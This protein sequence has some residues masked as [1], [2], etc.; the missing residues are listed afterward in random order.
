MRTLRYLTMTHT[1]APPHRERPSF[2][3][4]WAQTLDGRLATRSGSSQWIS[5]SASLLMTHRLRANHDAIMVG[6]RTVLADDPRLTV[7]LP[8]DERA[9]DT[10]DP[11][12]II[13]DSRLSIPITARVLADGA[14][15]GT[16]I[17]TSVNAEPVRADALR[18]LGAT[19]LSV[20]AAS[21]SDVTGSH[22]VDLHALAHLLA[23]RGVGSVMV[24]GGAG[25]L[26]ALLRNRLADRIVVTIA[27]K[28][29][30]EGIAAVG[31][32]GLDDLQQ[33]GILRDPIW[34]PYG[35]DMVLDG[36]LM[37]P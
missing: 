13:I 22:H 30:G 16:V 21:A 25:L 29:L 27:P 11:L 36:A 17:A 9:P 35:V 2:T 19:V 18:A 4:S 31:E 26:T 28:L 8:A 37:W 7:R 1:L 20:P 6:S 10:P 32:L 5:G 12:R 24:E 14:A 33:A 34:T 15:T 3:L 23:A